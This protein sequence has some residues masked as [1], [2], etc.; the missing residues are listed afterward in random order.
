MNSFMRKYSNITG[1]AIDQLRKFFAF[2]PAKIGAN[3]KINGANFEFYYSLHAIPCVGFICRYEGKS[4]YFS[5]DTYYD[6]LNMK[7][8]YVDKGFM[9][10]KR[11]NYL[12]DF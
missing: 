10:E 12:T 2:R 6:P 1:I 4:I 3:C 9:T 7:K 11:Y 5:A 8:N